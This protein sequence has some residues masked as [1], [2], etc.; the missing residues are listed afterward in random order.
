MLAAS[1]DRAD[2]DQ[3]GRAAGGGATNRGAGSGSVAIVGSMT[4]ANVD[5]SVKASTSNSSGVAGK[6]S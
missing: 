5:A 3:V 2:G 1:D 6:T 4:R